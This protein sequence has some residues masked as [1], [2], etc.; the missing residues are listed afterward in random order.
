MLADILEQPLVLPDNSE[1]A[2]FGAAALGFLAG[3]RLSG[4]ADTASLVHPRKVYMPNP[5]TREVYR[6]LYDIFQ[7]LYE[8]LPQEF[9]DIAAFQTKYAAR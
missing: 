2:A 1:G 9:A 5:D 4:V 7:R 6:S 8:K 3:G